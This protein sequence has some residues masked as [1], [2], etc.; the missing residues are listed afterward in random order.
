MGSSRRGVGPFAEK[1]GDRWS[2]NG[3]VI[4]AVACGRDGRP[5]IAFSRSGLVIYRVSR[6]SKSQIAR[7]GL[8]TRTNSK[9]SIHIF[10]PY[11]PKY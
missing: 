10:R 3:G 4:N 11:K 1:A 8:K 5:P 7:L 9:G 6:S 2:T